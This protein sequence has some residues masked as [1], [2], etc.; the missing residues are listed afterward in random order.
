MPRSHTSFSVVYMECVKHQTGIRPAGVTSLKMTVPSLGYWTRDRSLD[1]NCQYFPHPTC[2][3]VEV[4]SRVLQP[5][6]EKDRKRG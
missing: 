6:L 2:L 1:L 3:I 4:S 5:R